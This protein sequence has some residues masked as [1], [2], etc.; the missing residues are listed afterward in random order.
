MAAQ[1]SREQ[2]QYSRRSS[3]SQRRGRLPRALAAED[4][5]SE[6]RASRELP[7]PPPPPPPQQH[8]WAD[9]R[10]SAGRSTASSLIS[11]LGKHSSRPPSSM[12][13]EEAAMR[14]SA[15]SVAGAASG[16][17]PVRL[18]RYYG[19]PRLGRE[20]QEEEA[21]EFGPHVDGS[22]T[23]EVG[24]EMPGRRLDRAPLAAD[25]GGSRVSRRS[26]SRQARTVAECVAP[27]STPPRPAR[28]KDAGD[29]PHR[30]LEMTFAM[31]AFVCV[32]TLVVAF[33]VRAWMP[34][35]ARSDPFC[36]SDACLAHVRL[37]E[38]R[39]DR[40]VDPCV[41]FDAYAC[42]RWKPASE[43]YGHASALTNVLLDN[44]RRWA[45]N[46]AARAVS[47]A[48]VAVER[49]QPDED[50][51]MREA[52]A[53]EAAAVA[54]APAAPAQP[55]PVGMRPAAVLTHHLAAGG[56]A[57]QECSSDPEELFCLS[58][59]ADLKR[60]LPRER[61]MARMKMLQTLHDLEFG[62]NIGEAALGEP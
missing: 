55:C 7:P 30:T 20:R 1:G 43:F 41:D 33:V 13:D 57:A 36:R 2:S 39:I 11:R 35:E 26:A 12:L 40:G 5:L 23:W 50:D 48:E 34:Y 4:R 28:S 47:P 14:R 54:V 31:G 51:E 10:Q 24:G 25:A 42:S 45:L 6:A 19:P 46:G 3:R 37:I 29:R 44:W 53:A 16:M 32:A 9:S 60:L 27:A 22:R 21:A 18:T 61:H 56:A 49:E 58:L 38:A 62:E 17:T 15:T 52:A 8:P 59:A